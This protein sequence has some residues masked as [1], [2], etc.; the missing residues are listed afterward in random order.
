[1]LGQSRDL[2]Q[3]NMHNENERYRLVAL[4]VVMQ[5]KGRLAIRVME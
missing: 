2:H 5:F 4:R 1:M 3:T